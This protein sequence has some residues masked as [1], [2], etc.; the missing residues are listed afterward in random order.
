VRTVREKVIT[1]I[2]A[3]SSPLMICCSPGGG[4]GGGTGAVLNVYVSL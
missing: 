4:E 2:E 1:K 3:T